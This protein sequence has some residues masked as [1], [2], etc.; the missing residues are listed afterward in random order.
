MKGNL[1]LIPSFLSES[2]DASF[3]APMVKDV[4]C[5]LD[6]F[7][8]ENIRTSRRFISDLKLGIDISELEFQVLDKTSSEQSLNAFFE[9][10]KKGKDIGII[11]EAGLPGL[12]DPGGLAVAKAH[13]EGVK[14]VPLPGASAIQTAVSTSGFNGQQ[15]TFHGYLPIDGAARRKSIIQLQE[16]LKSTGYTQVFMETPF[17]N[18]S[19]LKSLIDHTS[20]NTYLHVCADCFGTKELTMTKTISEFAKGL[21]EIHKIPAVFCLG[22][23]VK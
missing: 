6:H 18:L 7:L 19:L 21:P 11:S 12:A 8:V 17:R 1:Y 10:L 4:V 5:N 14:V 15:F 20:G 16:Q 22:Q 13:R 2:N 9:L 3:I 23:F